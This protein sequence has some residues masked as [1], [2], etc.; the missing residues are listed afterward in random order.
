[1]KSPLLM[2]SGALIL[3]NSSLTLAASSAEVVKNPNSQL[4][5]T[6]FISAKAP[7]SAREFSGS[8]SVVT[9][10]EIKA[11]GATTLAQA[12]DGV[13]G[14]SIGITGSNGGE[15][16]RIRGMSAEYGLIL[17]DGKR[18]P[19][20][21]RN[22]PFNPANRNRWV[23]I[24]NIERIEVI[25]GAGSSLYGTDALSGV[26]NIITKKASKNWRSSVTLNARGFKSSGGEGSGVNISTS[27]PLSE[28]V[29]MKFSVDHQDDN[30]LD[31]DSGLSIRS[32][33]Q[34]TNTQLGLSIDID[35]ESQLDLGII[36]GE[37]QAIDT[38]APRH[39]GSLISSKELK[40]IKRLFSVDYSTKIADF[41]TRL[42]L[43]NAN[44]TIKQGRDDWKVSD[45]NFAVDFDGALNES[46]YLSTGFGYR[47]E[48][49]NRYDKD[50]S[51]A[52]KSTTGF[53]QDVIDVSENHALTLGFSFENHNKYGS[54]ASPKLYWSWMAS[55]QWTVKAGYSEGRIAPAIREGSSEYVI[56]AGP[57][58]TYQGND[59]LRP[60]ES[61]TL[62][63]SVGYEAESVAASVSLFN[64]NI[65][66]LIA[67]REIKTGPH[68]LALYSNI[69]KA[70]VRGLE[71]SVAWDINQQSKLSFNYTYLN[72]ENRSGSNSGNE[73]T[74]RPQHTAHLKFG[75]YVSQADAN[76]SISL[77]GVSSQYTDAQ[78]S[79]KIS[80]H[81]IVN[82]G[83]VKQLTKQIDISATIDNLNDRKVMDGFESIYA[84]R[85]YRISLTGRF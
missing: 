39:G 62:E 11:S 55:P 59:D 23:A 66:D 44:T 65:T 30:S 78:N 34:V 3:A 9:A 6:I 32:K 81:G 7:I 14:V 29:A 45:D 58:R 63:V 35:A 53:V 56:S 12:L 79:K 25:R 54:E 28:R 68:T 27:G 13:P 64:T 21:E 71:S 36:Y 73:L 82:V 60:E 8:V 47:N 17:I 74:R 42:N 20:A 24:E 75:H 16:I 67:A 1:M 49:A 83:F 31:D 41:N 52:F 33:R 2:L 37:E 50:F 40:Q 51:N 77:K 61:Q 18:I 84:G 5:D 4:K 10:K 57:N 26:I 80:G 15:E 22:V 85:E 69:N 43:S 70:R 46:H 19:N 76:I 72:T 48:K 38:D